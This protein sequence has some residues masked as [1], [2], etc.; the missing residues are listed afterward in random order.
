MRTTWATGM[1]VMSNLST[2]GCC[3]PGGSDE[4]TWAT[5]WD[6]SNWALSRLVPNWNQTL[7]ADRPC[8][9]VL[10]TRSMP[11]EE[12]TARSMGWVMD[13]SMSSGPAPG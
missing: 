2:N 5:R 7:I 4:S 6:T 10:S 11:G 13:F 8:L 12:L 1:L 3:T 9:L